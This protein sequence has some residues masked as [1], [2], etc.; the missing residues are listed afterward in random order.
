MNKKSKKRAFFVFV[1]VGLFY[2]CVTF[3]F[4][5]RMSMTRTSGEQAA[6]SR[7]SMVPLPDTETN[8]RNALSS[9]RAQSSDTVPTA[10]AE[11]DDRNAPP[12]QRALSPNAVP[13]ASAETNR[14]AKGPGPADFPVPAKDAQFAD[15]GEQGIEP[16]LLLTI[17]VICYAMKEGLIEKETLIFGRKDA[18][19]KGVWK[20]PIEILKDHD[21]DGIKNIL[22]TIGQKRVVEFMRKEGLSPA[23]GLSP[24]DLILG[25]GYRMDRERLVALYNKHVGGACDELFPFFVKEMGIEKGTYGFQ[26]TRSKEASRDSGKT[27]GAEWMM[28]NLANLPLRLAIAKLSVH[29]SRIRVYG[30]GYVMSQS[31]RAFERLKGE[32]E[33]IIQGRAQDE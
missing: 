25:K 13:T 2:I 9:E 26:L 18:Y 6:P 24:E 33:C 30:N 10:S 28:P 31:P 1:I 20:K 16:S 22:T 3:R 8:D 4:P 5:E 32:P 14:E 21:E 7:G 17:P 23:P 27:A 19:N 11:T 15:A 12:S 29:T